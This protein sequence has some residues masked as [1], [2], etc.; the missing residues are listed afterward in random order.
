MSF[1][2]WKIQVTLFTWKADIADVVEILQWA[3][4]TRPVGPRETRYTIGDFGC[5]Y[6]V[7]YLSA[8]VSRPY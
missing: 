7:S 4:R 3:V 2:S 1:R 5:G 6:N 8:W